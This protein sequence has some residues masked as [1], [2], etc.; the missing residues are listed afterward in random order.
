MMKLVR[1]HRAV[2]SRLD[3]LLGA[4]VNARCRLIE[5]QDAVVR[6]NRAG[7]RQ[8]LLLAWLT[9]EASSFSSIW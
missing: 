1:P 2:H 7:N 6:Q 9:L 8:K 3:A 4:G 5:D